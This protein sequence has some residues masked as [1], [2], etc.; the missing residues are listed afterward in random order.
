M[1]IIYLILIIVPFVLGC[2]PQF[3][4]ESKVIGKDLEMSFVEDQP[5]AELDNNEDFRVSIDLVN[6]APYD[7]DGELCLR[8]SL[9]YSAFG[10]LGIPQDS[11]GCRGVRLDSALEPDGVLVPKK[12]REIF[13]SEF[14]VYSYNNPSPISQK[15]KIFI[16]L[17]YIPVTIV[18]T[19]VCL[20]RERESTNFDCYDK[21]SLKL[22]QNP[23][24]V[25]IS[26]VD[27]SLI[28][29]GV[30]YVRMNLNI[31]LTKD[32][33]GVIFD[34]DNF[35]SKSDP[36]IDVGIALKDVST[37]FDCRDAKF[38]RYIYKENMDNI[39][40]CSAIIPITVPYK[41]PL[42]IVLIYGFDRTISKT[43][44]LKALSTT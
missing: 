31:Y 40:K 12:S 39:I 42:E 43:I 24:P 27:K 29:M 38:G 37:N 18:R 35:Y 7:V 21:E 41:N 32:T 15:F 22:D 11:A 20:K 30:D 6:K 14:G 28:N 33:D 36:Y 13:P 4:T 1:K 5:P 19:N 3:G 23:G 17:K 25:R 2:V 9:S 26:K 8:S 16:S 44:N 10:G 34:K